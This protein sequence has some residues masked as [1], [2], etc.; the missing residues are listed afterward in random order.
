MTTST[1]IRQS[2]FHARRTRAKA[3]TLIELLMV[4]A[5]VAIL[6][7]VTFG[8]TS[9]VKNSQNRTLAMADLSEISRGLEQFKTRY[10]DYPH[11][12]ETSTA[13]NATTL[14]RAL[15]GWSRLE[16]TGPA[17]S[18]MVDQ[19]VQRESFIDVGRLTLSDDFPEG[20]APADIAILDPWD[21]PYIY[22]YN[23]SGTSWENFGYVLMS[24]GPDGLVTLGSAGSDGLI[25]QAWKDSPANVD[26]L[27]LE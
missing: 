14:L 1:P 3:F 10:G 8:I 26:N 27:Y 9:G 12:A 13:A 16:K 18:A 15:T 6:A 25:D 22:I 19:T 7:A 20:A 5:V 2:S 24:S 21:N 11:I 23:V 4:M 17:T